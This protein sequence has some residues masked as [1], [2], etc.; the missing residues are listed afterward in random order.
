MRAF[1]FLL[2]VL[3]AW[4]A[5]QAKNYEG[6]PKIWWKTHKGAGF[7]KVWGGTRSGQRGSLRKVYITAK[8]KRGKQL[9]STGTYVDRSGRFEAY[10]VFDERRFVLLFRCA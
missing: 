6:C 1:L 7:I 3:P 2:L 4:G 10:L 5:A 8:K 9:D